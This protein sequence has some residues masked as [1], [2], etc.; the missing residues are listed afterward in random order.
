MKHTLHL[1]MGWRPKA[2]RFRKGAALALAT[3]LSVLGALAWHALNG[4]HGLD[5]LDTVLVD[6]VLDIVRTVRFSLSAG[7]LGWMFDVLLSKALTLILLGNML[8]SLTFLG[9]PTGGEQSAAGRLAAALE[10]VVRLLLP[11]LV[12]GSLFMVERPGVDLV[13]LALAWLL[14]ISVCLLWFWVMP[15]APQMTSGPATAKDALLI[16]GTVLALAL[17]LIVG[18]SLQ[19]SAIIA[20]GVLI[21]LGLVDADLR[22]RPFIIVR[23]LGQSAIAFGKLLVTAVAVGL[24]LT[25]LDR[26]GLPVDIARLLAGAAGEAKLPLIILSVIVAIVMGQLM[27]G[28]AAYLTTAA[29]IAPALRTVGVASPTTHLLIL[30]LTA[31]SVAIA[32]GMRSKAA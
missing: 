1:R 3:T 22:N 24:I 7:I 32:R 4:R 19:L 17:T 15:V 10:A 31:A 9:R 12:L 6:A 2:V 28:F 5:S 25:V 23:A 11:T 27:T 13:T 16:G 20:T 30:A 18:L 21:A 8:F 29:L 14:P 26:T